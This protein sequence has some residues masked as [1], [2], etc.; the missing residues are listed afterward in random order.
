LTL[1]RTYVQENVL[2]RVWRTIQ[3]GVGTRSML[4]WEKGH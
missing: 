1:L 4:V 3:I 2:K